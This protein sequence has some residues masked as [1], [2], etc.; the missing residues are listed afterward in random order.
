[1]NTRIT[2][3]ITLAFTLFILLLVG[4]AIQP[5]DAFDADGEFTGTVSES[6]TYALESVG[7]EIDRE[8]EYCHN[9]STLCECGRIYHP[10]GWTINCEYWCAQANDN[11]KSSC[12]GAN[13]SDEAR[14]SAHV[15]RKK[16]R[17][18]GALKRRVERT[19]TVRD[20]IDIDDTPDGAVDDC[21]S[22]CGDLGDG[23]ICGPHAC[24][25]EAAGSCCPT[26]ED[27][28]RTRTAE[29]NDTIEQDDDD[30]EASEAVYR[31][32]AAAR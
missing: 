8:G 25:T 29:D 31:T 27:G 32:P 12:E 23:V 15:Q 30:T 5:G 11:T 3:C 16:H 4:C 26:N 19:R 24:T 14:P 7:N 2:H 9:C 18:I 22:I 28:Q 10:G 13:A 20:V 1:M 21:Y 17:V 6:M